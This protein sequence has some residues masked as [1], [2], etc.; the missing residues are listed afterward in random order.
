[1]TPTFLPQH[2][3]AYAL[4]LCLCFLV[5]V[6]QAQQA[7]LRGTITDASNDEPVSGAAIAVVSAAKGTFSDDQ[8]SYR[9][10]LNT[11]VDYEVKVS[12]LGYLEQVITVNLGSD[13]QT[14]DIRL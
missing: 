14:L 7:E 5:S 4:T 1:M 10:L 12:L 8:G 6:L 2:Y 9:L 13:G 3:R 11:R